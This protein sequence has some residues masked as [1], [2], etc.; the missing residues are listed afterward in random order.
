MAD[1]DR[2]RCGQP[3]RQQA[4]LQGQRGGALPAVPAGVVDEDRRAGGELHADLAVVRVEAAVADCPAAGEEPERGPAGDQRQQQQRRAGQQLA[5]GRAPH[6]PGQSHGHVGSE[7]LPDR[8]TGLQALGMRGFGRVLQD[9]ADRERSFP[10]GVVI[11]MGDREPPDHMRSIVRPGG[12]LVRADQALQDQQAR[13]VAEVRND[14]ID[15][16]W[17]DLVEVERPAGL[18]D[19][20]VE[21]GAPH[22]RRV[23]EPLLRWRRDAQDHQRDK[24]R[25][26]RADRL[27]RDHRVGVVAVGG[28][29]RQHG[30]ALAIGAG[31][32]DEPRQA[33]A[34]GGSGD[35]AAELDAEQR[36]RRLGEDLAG[37]AI[38]LQ[39]HARLVD[40]DRQCPGRGAR[41]ERADV[42]CHSGCHHPTRSLRQRTRLVRLIMKQVP[43]Y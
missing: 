26:G 17:R 4:A 19:G 31:G 21:Q 3:G 43:V 37:C 33:A 6:G 25:V 40:P 13:R 35:Q 16:R 24:A 36:V 32:V 14:D 27:H 29:D 30:R 1:L 42:G 11:I 22:H 18:G 39:D 41:Q 23:E 2:G 7:I 15:E 34:V 28:L 12:Q 38:M 9:L 20:P 5:D 8:L 10:P